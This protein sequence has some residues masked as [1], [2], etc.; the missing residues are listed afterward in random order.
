MRSR[1]FSLSNISIQHR[2][3]LLIGL[4]LLGILVASTWASYLGVRDAALEVGHQRLLNLTQQ[5]AGL[6]QQSTALHLGKTV[7]VANDPAIVAYLQNPSDAGRPAALAILQHLNAAPDPNTLQTELWK[8]NNSLVLTNVEA[9]APIGDLNE[10]FK[11]CAVEPFK[12]VG[13][14]RLAKSLVV[15]PTIAAVKGVSGNAIGFLVRWRQISSNPEARKQLQNLVGNEA[16]LYF[17]STRGDI[18]TDLDKVVPEP[19]SGFQATQQATRFTRSGTSIMALGRPIH[20]T[21]FFVVVEFPERVFLAHATGFLRR[22]IVIDVALIVL[23]LVGSFALS[24]SITRP[25]QSLTVAAKRIRGGDYSQS[26]D[27]QQKDELGEL[28]SA[29][30]S[31]VIR[32]TASQ[33]DLERKIDEL[34][35]VQKAAV[36]LAAIVES[37]HDAIVGKTLDGTITSWNTSAE[38]LYGY[39]EAEIVGRSITLLSPPEHNGQVKAILERLTQGEIIDHF[40]TERI[41]KTGMRIAVSLAISPIRDESGAVS[42]WATIARDISERRRVER[43]LRTSEGL[44]RTLFDCAPYGIVIADPESYYIDANAT[45]CRMLGYTRAE[46]TELHASDIVA[47]TEIEQIG[48]A[49]S[50][51]K[52]KSDYHREW[53]FRRKDGS[54]FAAD[55]VSTMMPDGNLLGMIRD[56]SD[57]KQAEAAL[58]TKADELTAATQQL[59]QASKLATMGE[60]AASVAHELNNP[61]ATI[62]L[63]TEALLERLAADDP[64]RQALDVIAREV[65]RMASLVR[66]LLLFSRRSHPQTSTVN[67]GEEL[68]NS[69]D[70]IHYHMRS[71]RIHVVKE[72]DPALPM[73]QADRQQ[74]RQVFLNLLTNASDAMPEGG[75]L[76][77]RARPGFL[78]SGRAAAI[79]EFSDTGR[80]IE[81]EFLPKLFDSFFTTKPE[82]K[83][84]GLGLPI[85]RRTIEEHHGTIVVESELGIGTTVRIALPITETGGS[86]EVE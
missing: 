10:D 37:S 57:R 75:T 34:K 82:G 65:E 11:L 27:I 41:T 13:P 61:L 43:A 86:A 20:G 29:F 49:L 78:S 6:S 71:R 44:Y 9:S 51:I 50:L 21:P 84:T 83:G 39:T 45:M 79:L 36:K 46:L 33:E 55:V 80:G 40:E 19:P 24:G 48:P 66:N 32:L 28:A 47:P 67:L 2:L 35:L 30:N 68:T 58:Q 38:R 17:G 12:V 52:T 54:H 42:G 56:I 5:L 81:P 26:V 69:H 64:R 25:L 53:Q 8:S 63:R 85:C 59:W 70:F 18:W 7:A 74:L 16:A 15:Y 14:I 31:M 77:V 3:P 76:T 72:F 62:S 22:V 23:G 1:R 60:L 4:L 73:V